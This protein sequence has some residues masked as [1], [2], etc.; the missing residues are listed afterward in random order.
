MWVYKRTPVKEHLDKEH[1]VRHGSKH[2]IQVHTTKRNKNKIVRI[3][4]NNEKPEIE[5]K[6]IDGYSKHTHSLTHIHRHAL[7]HTPARAHKI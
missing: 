3:S 6:K 2:K 5:R 1:L 4:K 7:A